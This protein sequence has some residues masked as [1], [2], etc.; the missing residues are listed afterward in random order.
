[1]ARTLVD[2]LNARSEYHLAIKP[3]QLSMHQ[4]YLCADYQLKK[5]PFGKRI[6]LVLKDDSIDG[7]RS[8]FLSASFASEGKKALIAKAFADPTLKVYIKVV[9]MKELQNGLICPIYVFKTE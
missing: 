2:S 8:L 4:Y 3:N 9:E 5:T 7:F 6:M 1:M